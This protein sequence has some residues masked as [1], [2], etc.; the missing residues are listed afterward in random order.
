M[1][2]GDRKDPFRGFN[3]RLEIGGV[4]RAGFHECTGL[5]EESLTAARKLPGQTK[6]SPIILK[7]GSTDDKSLLQWRQRTAEHEP[8]R[9]NGS[10]IL[11]DENDEETS[12]V[13]GTPHFFKFAG[14]SRYLRKTQVTKL[15]LQAVGSCLDG[16]RSPLVHCKTQG[17]QMFRS[18]FEKNVH[19]FLKERV[20]STELFQCLSHIPMHIALFHHPS[21]VL[22]GTLSFSTLVER[23]T[24]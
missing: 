2:T 5:D 14:L 7:N 6:Y 18:F 23:E 22:I 21:L 1:P 15:S 20:I 13:V 12:E 4:V 11:M 10:I 19:D 3:F 8:E 17:C 24:H 16:F 9:K